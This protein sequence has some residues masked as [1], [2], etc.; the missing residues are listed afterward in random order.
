MDNPD[1]KTIFEELITAYDNLKAEV[2]VTEVNQKLTDKIDFLIKNKSSFSRP[3]RRDIINVNTTE[4]DNQLLLELSRN[5]LYDSL[6]ETLFHNENTANKNISFSD[7]RKKYKQ[8]EKDAR[9]F[10]SPIENEFFQQR[11]NIEENERNLLNNFYNLE[12]DFLIN[13][14]NIDKSIPKEYQL[15]LIKLLPFSFA[16]AGDLELARLSLE[17]VLNQKVIFKKKY[18]DVVQFDTNIVKQLGVNLITESKQASI[19]QPYLEVSIGP[20]KENEINTIANNK[21]TEN[22]INAFYSYFIPLELDVTTKLTT[23]QNE[24]FTL[25]TNSESRI[26]ITTTL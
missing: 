20:I 9:S 10:F 13:F 16:I 2:I 11:L 23:V 4:E 6:P 26:G 12:D 3:Y 21:G 5:G 19:A 1:L 17:K 15:K 8:E 18:K 7:K 22:F 14:W 25:S 24:G